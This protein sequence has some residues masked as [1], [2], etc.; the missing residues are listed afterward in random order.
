MAELTPF[1]GTWIANVGHPF[2]S[3]TFTWESEGSCL[4]GRWLIEAPDSPAER[5]AAAAGRPLRIEMQIDEPWLEDGLLLF[6][7]KGGPFVT[8]FRLVGEGEALVGAAAHK[9]P[10]QFAGPEHSRS[11]E[12]HRVRLTRQSDAAG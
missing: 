8:E 10:P 12:G 9:L 7:V 2:S 6:H 11:I 4:R 5:S 3:H 1:V